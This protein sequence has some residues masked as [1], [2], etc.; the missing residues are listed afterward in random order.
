MPVLCFSHLF[1]ATG[2]ALQLQVYS[3]ASLEA[4]S[5]SCPLPDDALKAKNKDIGD[6]DLALAAFSSD[7]SLLA[8]CDSYK[9]VFIWSTA[10][11]TLRTS[12]AAERRCVKLLFQD[13]TRLLAADRAGDVYGF[14]LNDDGTTTREL[15]LGHLSM[16]LDVVLSSCQKYL[17]SSDR[18]EKIRVSHYP[19]C[20]NIESYCLGHSEFVSSLC[21]MD[22][23]YLVSGSGDGTL[24]AWDFING[25][26][27]AMRN[28][29]EDLSVEKAPI[30][31]VTRFSS[32][33]IIVAFFGLKSL[34]MYHFANDY[35]VLKAQLDIESEPLDIAVF[36]DGLFVTTSETRVSLSLK[37]IDGGFEKVDSKLANALNQD[38]AFCQAFQTTINKSELNSLY[39]QWYDNVE[40]YMQRKKEREN[41]AIVN[42]TPPKNN[43]KKLKSDNSIDH[44]IMC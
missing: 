11:W 16:L 18:D 27:I 2:H 44:E 17:L 26:E 30:R 22:D 24:R 33:H 29:I 7:A 34:F 19:N 9:R 28:C 13:N 35:I 41:T 8:V 40:S 25:L 14:V 43:N 3:V 15:L 39:K 23:R 10:D 12:T 20:Y 1:V 37:Y 38:I 21:I 31:F 32:D 6:V 5:L 36:N 42:P 4:V